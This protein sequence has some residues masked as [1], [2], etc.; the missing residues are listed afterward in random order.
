[1]KEVTAFRSTILWDDSGKPR[2]QVDAAFEGGRV[3]SKTISFD[4]YKKLLFS[5][6][7][8]TTSYFDMSH[9][10]HFYQGFT[11]DKKGTFEVILVVP[12]GS[13]MYVSEKYQVATQLSYP[14][15]LFKLRFVNGLPSSKECFALDTDTPTN[16]SLLYRYPYG[17]VGHEGNICMGNICVKCTN[18]QEA[19]N[20]VD[21]FFD[22]IDE[23]HYYEPGENTIPKYNED[24]LVKKVLKKG[25]FPTEW[26]HPVNISKPKKIG[27]ILFRNH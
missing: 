13:H 20:F 22:G 24:E 25:Y 4:D 7:K 19:N 11:S 8:E 6:E 27:D 26:L 18:I 23:G 1:M 14:A 3:I 2:V 10:K 15:L 9:P 21:A 16:D 5:A 17:N 12:A